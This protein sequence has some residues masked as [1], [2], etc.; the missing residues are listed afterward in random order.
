M[1]LKPLLLMAFTAVAGR[2]CAQ[3]PDTSEK[4]FEPVLTAPAGS[5]ISGTNFKLKLN[6]TGNGLIHSSARFYSP[7]VISNSGNYSGQYY[8]AHF[9]GPI[10]VEN[11]ALINEIRTNSFRW[12]TDGTIAFAKPNTTLPS[13]MIIKTMGMIRTANALNNGLLLQDSVSFITNTAPGGFNALQVNPLITQTGYSGITRGVYV[14]PVLTDVSGF[15][16]IETNVPWGSGYQI[17][18]GGGARN[19]F[20][21][22]T[23]VDSVWSF[24]AD[25]YFESQLFGNVLRT[26]SL[27]YSDP[28]RAM[29]IQ[30]PANPAS[31][32]GTGGVL[33]IFA[34]GK[35]NIGN[36]NWNG[37][38]I[39]DSL[40]FNQNITTAR[41][42]SLR[43]SPVITQTG[44]T[45]SIKGLLI[46]PALTDVTDFRAIQTEVSA[47]KGYQLYAAGT[48]PSYFGGSVGI[49]TTATGDYKL[50]VEGTIGA[51]RIK[52]HTASWADYV[53]DSSYRLMPLNA[54]EKYIQD[55]KH[56]PEVPAA[57]KVAREGVDIGENQ[58][59][60]LKKIEE[61]TLYIIEQNKRMEAQGRQLQEQGEEIRQLKAKRK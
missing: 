43:V 47:G 38:G 14:N 18:A 17:Y 37:V 11:G 3:L 21:G 6:V 53:F 25:T 35:T 44:F 55:N 39:Y 40:L 34:W 29:Q 27:S 26:N 4:T 45:G 12:K 60:L 52:V 32:A 36:T 54:V 16:A 8:A 28:N 51:R 59:L 23:S 7:E 46:D 2:V 50:A 19:Y 10:L 57:A 5:N 30:K 22:V 20:R 24:K 41:I 31:L 33:R 13:L 15:R 61:L 1:N 56:L 48:A 9:A 49:G 42:S 58:V